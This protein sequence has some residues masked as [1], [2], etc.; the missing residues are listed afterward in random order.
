MLLHLARSF[1]TRGSISSWSGLEWNVPLSP[2]AYVEIWPFLH[3]NVSL[4]YDVTINGYIWEN[5]GL[6]SY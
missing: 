3:P 2:Q 1:Q 4:S 6:F 5:M